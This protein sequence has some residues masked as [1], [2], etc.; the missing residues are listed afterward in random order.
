MLP[1]KLRCFH[2]DDLNEG[3]LVESIQIATLNVP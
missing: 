1:D 2:D 3:L